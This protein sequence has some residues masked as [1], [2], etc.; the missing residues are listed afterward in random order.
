MP[1]ARDT[2]TSTARDGAVGR[3]EERLRQSEERFQSVFDHAP[4]GILLLDAEVR[5][6][7][8][9]RALCAMLQFPEQ[10]LI[11]RVVTELIHPADRSA[12]DAMR[13]RI[14]AG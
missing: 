1:A 5:I 10:E 4:M 9:N 11:G 2:S 13:T 6:Q 14:V 7:R 3:A 12:S 8:A